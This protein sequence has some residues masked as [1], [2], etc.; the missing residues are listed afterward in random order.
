[1]ERT[2]PANAQRYHLPKLV[3]ALFFFGIM[4]TEMT[5]YAFANSLRYL[6]KETEALAT[7]L[8]LIDR[9]ATSIAIATYQIRDDNCGGQILA[10]LVDAASRGVDV[11]LLVDAHPNNNNLPKPLIRYLVEHGIAIKERPFDV[12]TKLELGRPRLHDKLFIVDSTNLIMGGRNLEQDYFG[13]GNRKYIDID[14][15]VE[16]DI[17]QEIEAYF[18][19]RWNE[20]E[21]ATPRLSGREEPKM[22]KKQMHAEWNDRSYC[23]V[24]PEIDAWLAQLRGGELQACDLPC[25]D[26]TGINSHDSVCIEFLRDYTNGSKRSPKAI[27]SRIINEIKSAKHSIAIATPYFVVPHYLRR[28]LVA[29]S[30]RGVRVTVLTNS[31]ES[32]DQVVVHASY[33]NMRR[34]LIRD[35]I[36]I[37]ELRG[38]DILHAK[39]IV[40]DG[41]KT[42]IG[43]HNLDML[44]MTRNSEVGLLVVSR[45][46]AEDA[47]MLYRSMIR[48][49]TYLNNE[50]LIRYEKRSSPANDEKLGQY[51]RL[52]FVTPFI[53]RYL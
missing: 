53:R 52:R 32:T 35:G 15:A 42:I 19:S 22:H 10:A 36:Q 27:S 20:P 44:S 39:L 46:F 31:L 12:R 41:H 5:T 23:E 49:S 4:G 8:E 26:F 29:A 34:S 13:L 33:A 38:S 6:V 3:F 24:V 43:S 17:V 2:V 47:M 37:H 48:Q 50:Q 21:A 30:K 7:R 40:I 18:H 1:V 9:A 28:E 45:T 14:V 16:G 11:R 25:R 51:Q